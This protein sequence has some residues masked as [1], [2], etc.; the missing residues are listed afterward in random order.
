MEK[1]VASLAGAHAP[2]TA[3]T[4]DAE[5]DRSDARQAA[6]PFVV[7]LMDSGTRIVFQILALG[8]FVALGIFWRWWLRDEHYVDAFR[9]GV[10]GFVLFWTTFIPGYFIFIIRSAVVPNPALPVPRDW[11]VAMVVT[12]APSEP[13]DIVRTTLLAMLDQTYPHDTWLADEDP[14]PATLDWCRAHGVFVSTRRGIAAYHRASWPRRTRCK[15]GNLAYFYDTVGYDHYDFVSQLDADHVPTRTYLEEMLRPFVDPGIGYVSAPSICDSNAAGSWSAR[16]RVNVE[17]PLHGTMQ[18]GYAGGLAPLCIGSHYAV[19]CRA[20]REI[21]GLGP[22]LAED[23]STTM[24]FNAKGWRGMHALNAIA[25]G[26]GPRTFGDL[27]T[28]EFQWSR[29]VMIIM[30]RYTRRYFMGLPPKLKAQFLFCQLWYPLC[31]LA[32]AGSVAIPVVALLTGRVWAHVDYLTY[33]TYALPLSVLILCVVTWAT[34]ATQ[35]C[36]PLNTKLLSWEGLTFVFARWPWVVLGCVSALL[37]CVRGREFPFKVTP[38]GG[39]VEQDAPL[40]VVAPYLLISLFCSLPVVAIDNPRNAAGFYLFSTLT[41]ILYLV[42]AAVI[43]VQHGKEQGLGASTFRQM[44]ASR[45]PVRNA[46]FVFALAM[47]LTGI[48]LRAPKGW[49]AMVWRSGVPAVAVAEPAPG[50]AVKQPALGAYDPGKVFTAMPGIAFDHVFVSWNAP[51]IDAEIGDAYRASQAHNRSLLLTVE[52]WAADGTRP[53]ALLDDIAHG[54]YDARIAAT[55]SALAALKGPVFVRWGHEMETDTGRYPWAVGDASA[56]VAAYRRVVTAC[57]AMT[58]RIRFVWSPAGNR[59]LDDYFPGRGYVDEVGLS[60]FDCPRCAIWPLGGPFSAANILRAKYE[61]VADYGLPV[62]VAELGVD[63][64]N[65]R[66]RAELDEFQRSLWRYP[67]L[68]AVVYFNAVDTPG[69]W[70]AHYVPDWR[71]APAFLQTTVVAK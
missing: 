68:N 18:A 26:E 60:V 71:I 25:N 59:N 36:R 41:S 45:L 38:K 15:E 61:R 12:K 17:G 24:I 67:L 28:Q 65:A 11:R 50:A 19:R 63:G 69:A 22:E 30:L 40:R 52:P 56:Y 70:P 31:A 14:S 57:R 48:G 33:L 5:A 58:D 42:I 44:F 29:S 27:A 37:D 47:L 13:F 53:G 1:L 66:K 4:A 6:I 43:A 49:Q 64:S 8:W 7:P 51:D 3:D 16:G 46:L 9:F 2:A 20:L 32:M 39:T 62:M 54:R 23:H 55:C 10:N 35:S 21:G 34:Q